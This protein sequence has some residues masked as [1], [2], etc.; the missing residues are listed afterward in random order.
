MLDV[1][2]MVP[3]LDMGKIQAT[4]LKWKTGAT[5]TRKPRPGAPSGADSDETCAP[6]SGKSSL[7]DTSAEE[8]PKPDEG[9]EASKSKDEGLGE[10]VESL[11]HL[12]THLPKNPH[13]KWCQRAKMI[14]K[15]AKPRAHRSGL[16]PKNWATH[17]RLDD[18]QE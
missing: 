14:H 15:H 2:D 8:E 11:Y 17:S 10:N 4:N 7:E 6:G 16:A 3:Y 1:V 5:L 13:C 12:M 9:S 18:S